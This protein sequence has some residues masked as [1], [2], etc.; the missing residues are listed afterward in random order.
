MDAFANWL[1]NYDALIDIIACVFTVLALVFTLYFWLLDHLS[2]D[3]SKFIE[4]KESFLQELKECLKTISDNREPEVLLP[5]VQN[6]NNKL[7]V[8]LN[9]RFW[10][11]SRQKEDYKKINEFYM[12]SKYL[13]STIRRYVEAQNQTGEE[14][15]LVG[16]NKLKKED[17]DDIQSDYRN[18]LLFIIDFIESWS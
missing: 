4:G 7:E 9:Y 3:E 5:I 6:V 18:G 13:I 16:I 12:D 11:R 8:I 10:P 15:S 17:L 14:A 1:S 2:E